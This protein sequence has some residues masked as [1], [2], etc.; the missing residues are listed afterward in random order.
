MTYVLSTTRI[1]DLMKIFFTEGNK[2]PIRDEVIHH[3][4]RF[5]INHE[6]DKK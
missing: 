2:K 1:L 3:L 5:Y 6:G 4:V